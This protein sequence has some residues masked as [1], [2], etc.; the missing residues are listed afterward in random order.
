MY[1]YLSQSM[2]NIEDRVKIL[3]KKS[4]RRGKHWYFRGAGTRIRSELPSD[5]IQARRE[6]SEIF[7]ALKEDLPGT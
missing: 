4:Q 2:A 6:Q 5:T 7:Q 1:T 3:K